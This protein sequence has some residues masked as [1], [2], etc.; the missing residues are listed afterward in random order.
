MAIEKEQHG[1][2]EQQ[3]SAV[4]QDNLQHVNELKVRLCCL[5]L[6][7]ELCLYRLF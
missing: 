1:D 2:T 6:L 4:K 3:L 7:Q 5:L